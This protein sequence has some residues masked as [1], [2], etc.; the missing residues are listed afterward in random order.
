MPEL[1]DTAS[2]LGVRHTKDLPVSAD[3]L[4]SPRTGGMSVSDDPRKLPPFLL[5]QTEGGAKAV[6]AV[7]ALNPRSLPFSL[8]VRQD[9]PDTD[10]AHH[11]V[12][13]SMVCAFTTYRDAIRGTRQDWTMIKDA[14]FA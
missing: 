11:C 8:L 12:E 2:G 10:P 9:R 1:S 6:V 3:G 13:P 4:V 5:H 7:F 14:Q